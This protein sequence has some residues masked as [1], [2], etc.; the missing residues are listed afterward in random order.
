[1]VTV[2][3]L[4]TSPFESLY[5]V[6]TTRTVILKATENCKE[7]VLSQ[8]RKDE[9]PFTTVDVELEQTQYLRYVEISV[10]RL[11]SRMLTLR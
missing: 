11:I 3:P 4:W 1:M 8:Y 7:F 9:T 2:S 10:L 5:S 6:C